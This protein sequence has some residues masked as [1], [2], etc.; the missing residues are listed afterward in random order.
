IFLPKFHCELNP[1]EPVSLSVFLEFSEVADGTFA[2]ARVEVPLCLDR[3]TTVVSKG[4]FE[5]PTSIWIL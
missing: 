1:I 2:T 4:F 5:S 3:C